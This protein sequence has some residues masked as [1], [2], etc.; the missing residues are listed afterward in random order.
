[1]AV[2]TRGEGFER[3]LRWYPAAWRRRYGSELAALLE[4]TYPEGDV[5]WRCRLSLL[6]A[7][8]AERLRASGLLGSAAPPPEGA[9]AGSLL[10]L[11][12]W[13]VFVMAGT[14]F[15]KLA[16]NWSGAVPAGGAQLPAV[17]YDVVY[18]AG[19]AGGVMVLLG[20]GLCAPSLARL[21]RARGWQPIRR[22]VTRA[23]VVLSITIT[24]VAVMAVWAHQL[25]SRER[26]GGLWTYSALA[27]VAALLF[28]ATVISWT[29]AAAA[30]VRQL[31][32]APR[33]LRHCGVLA[34]A[35]TMV[36][37]ALVGGTVAWWAAIASR[38]PWFLDGTAPGTHGAVAP[39]ALVVVGVLM[40]LA[41]ML[42]LIGA[43]RA[44]T[45]LRQVRR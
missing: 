41:L 22:R 18:G 45:S 1:V 20:A 8:L 30:V 43:R 14:G 34:V 44:T 6:Q 37:A 39:P 32:L 3:V 33:T 36:M 5:P 27:V 31:E 7:G 24:V 42:G 16:E 28:T 38:A 10:V 23:A 19:L 15:A 9:R 40:V 25:S 4:D 2:V 21:V 26:N 12:A 13:A 11:W 17:G 29:A 35:L